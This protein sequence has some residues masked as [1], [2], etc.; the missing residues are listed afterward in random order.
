MSNDAATVY[1]V[2]GLGNAI[3]DVLA[4]VGDG[5]LAERGLDKGQMTLLDA[6]TAGEIYADIIP[7]REVSGGSAA[8]TV[9]AIASLGGTPAFIGKVHDDE[10]GQEFRRD[11][12][13]AGVDFFTKPLM[14]GPSTGRSIVLVTPDAERSMFTY[15]GAATKLSVDDVDEDIIKSAKVVYLEGYLWDDESAKAAMLKACDL[16]HKY[17]R[18]V[19]FSLSDKSCVERHRDDFLKL[20]H[21]RVDILFANEHEIMSLFQSDDFYK[22]LDMVKPEVE[23][24]A[25]TR[26]SKGS[27]IVNNRIK[28]FVEAEKVNDVVDTTGAGDLY[29]AGFLYGYTQG[30]TLGTSAMIGSIAASE[31][32]SHYGARAE[33]SLRGFV[34]NKLRGYDKQ[35]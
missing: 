25:V 6:K 30:R 29:A 7:E 11:I 35:L 2:V 28:I 8:N 10:L 32:I 14:Q 33:V 23:I 20:V 27:V 24:A 18:K 31:I 19:A 26:S 21:E 3:I 17:N 4:K 34:R 5:F 22:T 16:A 15:L 12:G 1:D 9:A 13:A